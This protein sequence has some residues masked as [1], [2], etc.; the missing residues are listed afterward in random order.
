L[1]ELLVV[2]AIIA[3]LIGLLLPAVQKVREAANRIKCQNNLKQIGLALHSYHDANGTFPPGWTA[4][5]G[6]GNAWTA[7]FL[8]Y[9]EQ[10]NLYQFYDFS[11]PS[12]PIAYQL[13]NAAIYQATLPIFKCP[14]SPDRGTGFKGGQ[15]SDYFS[16]GYVAQG[17]PYINPPLTGAWPGLAVIH[18][19][20]GFFGPVAITKI[21]DGTSNTL[22]IIEDAGKNQLWINGKL[23]SGQTF[24]GEWFNP[25]PQIALVGFDPATMKRIG[26]C[27]LDCWNNNAPYSFHPG[28]VQAV[29]ADGAVHFLKDGM[30]LTVMAW[31]FT[32]DGGEVL[33][34]DVF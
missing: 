13:Q 1:I 6:G 22:L 15:F 21:S 24:N 4:N 12:N 19:P 11:Q 20:L 33:P 32:Y 27:A 3:V 2:I 14:S 31:L 5:G 25:N 8:P 28:G 18:G 9:I 17:N 10:G 23:Q 16:A 7:Y 26:P 29:F 30:S 34:S